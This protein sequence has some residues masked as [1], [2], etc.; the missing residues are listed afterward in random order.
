MS[1]V[2]PS[3]D[4]TDLSTRKSGT[5]TEVRRRDTF[6]DAARQG[7]RLV[8]INEIAP[9]AIGRAGRLSSR[10]RF[11]YSLAMPIQVAIEVAE[12]TRESLVVADGE[13]VL[14]GREPDPAR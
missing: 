5:F 10:L 2:S 6:V 8:D 13:S 4:N 3:R 11:G 14:V 7:A 9:E 12:G 1:A